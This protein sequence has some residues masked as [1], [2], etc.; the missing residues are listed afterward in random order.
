VRDIVRDLELQRRVLTDFAEGYFVCQ[1]AEQ[2]ERSTR[3]LESQIA[4]MQERIDARREM[5]AD[6]VRLQRPL[7]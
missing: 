6:L 5:A 2:A 4:N 7:L 1:T 3:R